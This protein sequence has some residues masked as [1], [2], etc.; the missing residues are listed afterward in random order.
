LRKISELQLN[1]LEGFETAMTAFWP[2]PNLLVWSGGGMNKF[3][4]PVVVNNGGT[5]TADGVFLGGSPMTSTSTSSGAMGFLD[6]SSFRLTRNTQLLAFDISNSNAIKLES[7]TDLGTTNSVAFTVP[8]VSGPL[9]YNSH[10]AMSFIPAPGTNAV[11]SSTEGWGGPQ[12]QAG[13]LITRWF[14]NVVDFTDSAHPVVRRRVS[15][16]GALRGV[17]H[18]GE[19]LY[20]LGSR[21]NEDGTSDGK[22]WLDASAY[23]GVAAYLVDSLEIPDRPVVQL[24][25]ADIFVAGKATNQLQRWQLSDAGVLELLSSTNI[26]E[27]I[28]DARFLG[29]LLIAQSSSNFYLFD[30]ANR[31][32]LRLKA[33]DSTPCGW[34]FWGALENAD[35]NLGRGLWVPVSWNGVQFIPSP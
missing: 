26:P 21:I 25:A 8:V 4:P 30:A 20:T 24:N 33:A 16:P 17:T 22:Q 6:T 13:I 5:T 18:R 14:L 34:D 27:E 31:S 10:Q 32:D 29:N 23:D 19:I 11:S 12:A 15:I 2:K 1:T 28:R 7:Q 9:I 35:G 3:F